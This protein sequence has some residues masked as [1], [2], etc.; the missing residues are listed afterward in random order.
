M[1]WAL[2]ATLAVTPALPVALLFAPARVPV[3]LLRFPAGPL[4]RRLAALGTAIALALRPWPV[5]LLAA[6]Q[7]TAPRTRPTR[8]PFPRSRSLWRTATI[9]A[10]AH[11][12]GCS[13][14]LDSSSAA[15]HSAA[16][17]FKHPAELIPDFIVEALLSAGWVLIPFPAQRVRLHSLLART[18]SA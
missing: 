17:L 9:L 6:F 11:G 5:A 13:Q 1:P 16:E 15:C 18:C 3:S 14:K 12:S 10:W 4:T 8:A 2:F 7:Q